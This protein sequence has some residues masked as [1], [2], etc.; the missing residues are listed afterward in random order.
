MKAS[1]TKANVRQ[2]SHRRRG[3]RSLICSLLMAVA[4]GGT[5]LAA[6]SAPADASGSGSALPDALLEEFADRPLEIRLALSLVTLDGRIIM[7]LDQ[8]T[9]TK[10]RQAVGA[11]L[12]QTDRLKVEALFTP[13]WITAAELTL[14]VQ[15]QIWEADP[16]GAYGSEPVASAYRAMPVA[17]GDHVLLF[18]L[19]G[20]D[21]LQ[22]NTRRFH[23][24]ADAF[25]VDPPRH[26]DAEEDG[27]VAVVIVMAVQ[28]DLYEENEVPQQQ[29]AVS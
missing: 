18:P 16:A 13:V 7:K 15:L 27:P 17:L 19:G 12:E 29:N 20:E 14:H 11:T 9:P 5:P 6:Q 2:P 22:G 3:L 21:Q 4:A 25:P 23:F 24:R 26:N 10:P 28:V 1:C 8:S